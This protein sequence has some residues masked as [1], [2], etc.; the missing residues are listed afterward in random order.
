MNS[1]L[2]L[3]TFLATAAAAAL[4][5]TLTPASA[6][7]TTNQ[8]GFQVETVEAPKA[9]R[10]DVETITI[11]V[12]WKYTFTS[13]ALSPQNAVF[14]TATLIWDEPTCDGRG[15][16]ITGAL[17]QT[18]ALPAQASAEVKGTS[19][20]NVK[21]TDQAPGE[22]AVICTFQGKVGPVGALPQTPTS[23]TTVP[24]TAAYYGLIS[25]NVPVTI[26]QAGPQ[27]QITYTLEVTNLGNSESLINVALVEKPADDERWQPVTPTQVTLT[28]PNKGGTANTAAINFLVSTPYKNGW[29][30]KE[31]TFQLE[32]QPISVKDPEQKGNTIKVNVLARVRGI[33]VP[34]PEPALMMLAAVGAA[35]VARQLRRDE[36]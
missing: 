33:Y 29:N 18:F 17:S 13:A 4:A 25:A 3:R 10:V 35:V 30:N 1:K 24:I 9:L 22:T 32:I 11:T 34:G 27:K 21:V 19:K 15:V 23:R 6:Q 8:A 16:V 12:P 36:E 5:L 26:A 7:G 28:S 20:F 14:S 31:G 2:V